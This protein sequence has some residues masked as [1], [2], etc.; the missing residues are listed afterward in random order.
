VAKG[1]SGCFR[2]WCLIYLSTIRWLHLLLSLWCDHFSIHVMLIRWI[3]TRTHHLW[4]PQESLKPTLLL[5]WLLL[6]LVFK[7]QRYPQLF[8][9]L[10]LLMPSFLI[11]KLLFLEL[12]RRW[13]N[14]HHHYLR[15]L[16]FHFISPIGRG[17]Q[18][19]NSIIIIKSLFIE[20]EGRLVILKIARLNHIIIFASGLSDHEWLLGQS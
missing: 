17:L 14:I 20:L 18:R 15:H 10:R 8:I 19:L 6:Q 5:L 2:R 1:G 3:L 16:L 12:L 13:V 4:R 7:I 11:L 9:I